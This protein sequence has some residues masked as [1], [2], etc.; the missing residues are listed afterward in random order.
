MLGIERVHRIVRFDFGADGLLARGAAD[1]RAARHRDAAAQQGHRVPGV[2]ADGLP[3]ARHADR[4][5]RTRA[6]RRRQHQ[7]LPDRRAAARASSRSSASATSTSATARSRRGGDLLMLE[8]RFSLDH[9][10]VGMR[11]RRVPL[12]RRA[13]R[14]DGRRPGADRGR[15]GLSDR[16]HGRAV[17]CTAPRTARLVLTL[18]SDDNFSSI[19]RTLLLQFTLSRNE[20]A[21][22]QCHPGRAQRDPR[23]PSR[24]Q[25]RI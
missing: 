12:A 17:A 10:G 15:Y 6:R 5:L 21:S 7:G 16:Q 3:L 24:N 1:R 11:I 19:Q 20:G 22:T 9:A 4:D 13:A 25:S 14:R 18:I 8:R 23:D 2:R